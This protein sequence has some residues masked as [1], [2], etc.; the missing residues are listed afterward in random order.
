MNRI[1]ITLIFLFT[2]SFS[3]AQRYSPYIKFEKSVQSIGQIHEENGAIKVEYKF[4]NTGAKPLIINEIKSPTKRIKIDWVKKPI[5]PKKSGIVTVTYNP[6]RKKGGFN[7]TI[8]II[9][10]AK[11]NVSIIRISGSVIP[12]PLTLEEQYPLIKDQLRFKKNEN[13]IYFNDIKNTESKTDTIHY[14]NYSNKEV[15]L[16]FK[17]LPKHI[18]VKIIPEIVKPKQKGIMVVAF[19]ATKT[20]EYGY[21]YE[22]LPLVINKDYKFKNNI[23]VNAIIVEDFTKLS[24]E[25]IAKAPIVKF[26]DTRFNFG[27]IEQG[28]N[29]THKYFFQNIGKSDLIVRKIKAGCGCTPYMTNKRYIKPGE[30]SFLEVTFKSKGRRGR[31]HK[32]I[33]FITND[34]KNHTIKLEIMGNITKPS[35]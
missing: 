23:T 19:D 6:K 17:Y 13:R 7:R 8:T 34:P 2:I 3:F 27:S 35:K 25:Q 14:M 16:S 9:S 24:K 32:F 10:N 31:Q 22:R 12:R 21:T 26:R 5:L 18:S 33:T 30:S 29:I 15:K 11:N 4:T 20:K 28:K 1:V